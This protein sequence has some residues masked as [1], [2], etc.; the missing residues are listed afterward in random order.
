MWGHAAYVTLA[1]VTQM[2]QTFGS[3]NSFHSVV[4]ITQSGGDYHDNE[5]L[6]LSP[7]FQLQQSLGGHCRW[8]WHTDFTPGPFPT[9]LSNQ[10]YRLGNLSNSFT[11]SHLLNTDGH[12]V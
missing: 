9:E 12:M 3:T 8:M 10:F 1:L 2:V 11:G 4:V 5:V 6:L 7:A